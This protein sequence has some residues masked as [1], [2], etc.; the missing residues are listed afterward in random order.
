[1]NRPGSVRL[2]EVEPDLASGLADEERQLAAQIAVPVMHVAPGEL[3]PGELLAWERA[4]GAIVLDGMVLQR[5]AIGGHAALRLLGPG[6]M[7][8]LGISRP[9]ML[10]DAGCRVTAPVALA[11][12]EDHM[13]LAIRRFPQLGVAL[14][15][16]LADQQ[17]R[18]T[19]QLAICQLPRVEDRLLAMMWLLA[20]SWGR[21]SSSGTALPISLTHDALGELVGAKR[22]TVTLA[23]RELTDQGMVVRTDQGWLLLKRVHETAA[24]Q[25]R[26]SREPA[27]IAHI[28]SGWREAKIEA[29]THTELRLNLVDTVQTLR[30][31]HLREAVRHVQRMES[32]TQARL[33][34][35]EIRERIRQDGLTR[36]GPS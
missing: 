6:D 33:R 20:E 31:A 34:S 16:R 5:S 22:P 18:L 15:L 10:V 29:D 7:L 21:V 24:D 27:V 19:A 36:R 30:E 28:P 3:Q 12:L 8:A 17:E 11:V 1:M 25:P 23:L 4:F 26:L 14:Q 35:R 13:I 2:L 9:G 32:A